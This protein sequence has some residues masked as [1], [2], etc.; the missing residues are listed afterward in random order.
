MDRGR[1]RL[2]TLSDQPA[3][4]ARM[5]DVVGEVH[6]KL[7]DYETADFLLH[8]SVQLQRAQPTPNRE[9]LGEYLSERASVQWKLGRYTAADSLA[10]RALAAFSQEVSVRRRHEPSV[11]LSQALLA[12]ASRLALD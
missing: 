1:N 2:S 11:E 4:Q 12:Q 9:R 7:S 5:F 3:L 10:R 6:E 8:R